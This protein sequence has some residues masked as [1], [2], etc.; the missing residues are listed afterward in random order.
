M[1]VRNL[2]PGSPVV[3]ALRRMQALQNE[4]NL[5]ELEVLLDSRGWPEKKPGGD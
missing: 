4:K 5:E 1:A 2:G 3:T